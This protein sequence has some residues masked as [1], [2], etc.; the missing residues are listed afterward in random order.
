MLA[1]NIKEQGYSMVYLAREMVI[2]RSSSGWRST[3]RVALL[4]SGSS[5]AKSTPLCANDISPGCGLNPPP[6]SATCE[7]VWWGERKGRC[8]MSDMPLPSFPATECIWVVSRLSAS[9]SGGSI[10]GRRFAIIDLPLPGGPIIMRLWPPAAATSMARFTFSCP[11]TSLKSSSK[12][13]CCS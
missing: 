13:A 2:L 9:D 1:T 8:E 10:E 3:S 5:S 4:N 12:F 11:R 7:M 6:T